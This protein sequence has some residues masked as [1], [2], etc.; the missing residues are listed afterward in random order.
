MF[1]VQIIY[2]L[3]HHVAGGVKLFST[4]A[5]AGGFKPLYRRPTFEV[6]N[7]KLEQLAVCLLQIF[8]YSKDI[9]VYSPLKT[10][11]PDCV[12]L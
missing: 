11:I 8:E 7:T 12:V 10:L 2:Y 6:Q 9:A 3:C 4:A 1:T 5:G